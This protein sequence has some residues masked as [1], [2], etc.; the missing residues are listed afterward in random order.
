MA[1]LEILQHYNHKKGYAVY[2]FGARVPP[3]DTR[4]DIFPM[5][6]RITKDLLLDSRRKPKRRRPLPPV[7]DVQKLPQPGAAL[8]ADLLRPDHS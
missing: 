4:S 6:L 2:G 3:Y 5:V 1:F 7:E 8:G